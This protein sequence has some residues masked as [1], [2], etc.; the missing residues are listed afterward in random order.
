MGNSIRVAS[1]LRYQISAGLLS[2]THREGQKEN[3]EGMKHE[4]DSHKFRR[5]CARKG[6]GDTQKT[7]AFPQPPTERCLTKR[8]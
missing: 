6:N 5:V 3:G 2:T 4:K 1:D 8:Q 7:L